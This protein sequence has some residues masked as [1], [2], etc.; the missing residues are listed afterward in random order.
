LTIIGKQ[1][2]K[3]IVKSISPNSAKITDL[4][5]RSSESLNVRDGSNICIGEKKLNIIALMTEGSHCLI[6]SKITGW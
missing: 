2:I 6:C 3:D 4:V 5:T 1:H